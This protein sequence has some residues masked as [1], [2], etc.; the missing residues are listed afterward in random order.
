[1]ES[2][3]MPP[4]LNR[5]VPRDVRLTAGGKFVYIVAA[6]LLVASVVAVVVLRVRG[7]Q[8]SDERQLLIERGAGVD[9][10]IVRLWRASNEQKQPW[11]A[12]RFM[13]D[14]REYQ[15]Q[16]QVSLTQWRTL[17]VGA[18]LP[19]RYVPERPELSAPAGMERRALPLW[20]PYLAATPL[21]LGG[22]VCFYVVRRERQLLENGRPAAAIVTGHRKHR[23]SEGGTHRSITY[24]FRLLSGA[25]G[26]GR[27]STSS[28]PPAIGSTICVVYDPD[29]P[30][31]SQP[32]PFQFVRASVE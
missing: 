12:Y 32:Y 18:V 2:L 20:V 8:E 28:K 31:R 19:V 24:E 14:G 6:A 27:S 15:G 9:A 26:K 5:G 22:L 25:P 16:T 10:H 13:V 23:S 30:R 11:L 3:R 29:R 4:G 21:V 1:M 7:V 17:A